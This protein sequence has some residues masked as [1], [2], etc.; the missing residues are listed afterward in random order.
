[1]TP[2]SASSQPEALTDAVMAA[3]SHAFGYEGG[4][5]TINEGDLVRFA[6]ILAARPGATAAAGVPEA[7][8]RLMV[9]AWTAHM[10]EK[11]AANQA[12]PATQPAGEAVQ[13]LEELL[14]RFGSMH[15]WVT[16]AA[17]AAMVQQAIGKLT[18][19]PAQQALAP[20][21]RDWNG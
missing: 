14:E 6:A 19:T 8:D 17:A 13:V 7:R 2:I 15:T 18:A 10:R 4:L 11:R 21:E 12:Q 16:N 9:D 3:A 20:D 5:Q 1:M